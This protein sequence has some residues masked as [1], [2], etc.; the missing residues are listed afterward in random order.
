MGMRNLNCISSNGNFKKQKGMGTQTEMG[1][2]A[3]VEKEGEGL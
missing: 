1:A 3:T 2:E